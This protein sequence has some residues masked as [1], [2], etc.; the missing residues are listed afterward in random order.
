L[1]GK[2]KIGDRDAWVLVLTSTAGKTVTQYVDAETFLLT[3]QL[4]TQQTAQGE[5]EMKV[6]LSDYRDVSGVK[7]PFL[8]KQ[9]LPPGDIIIKFTEMQNNV[10]IDDAKFAKPAK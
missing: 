1:K 5:M 6:E 9:M 3:R 8:I 7:V 10:P 4:M 2:E